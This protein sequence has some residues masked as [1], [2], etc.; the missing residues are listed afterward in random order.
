MRIDKVQ[1]LVAS[2]GISVKTK[3]LFHLRTRIIVYIFRNIK[4][5]LRVYIQITIIGYVNYLII[6]TI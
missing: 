3:K 6:K 1:C 5:K 4:L 2:D